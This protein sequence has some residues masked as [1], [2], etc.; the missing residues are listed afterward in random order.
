MGAK[1]VPGPLRELLAAWSAWLALDSGY[2]FMFMLKRLAYYL[3]GKINC[4][5]PVP[6]LGLKEKHT[7]RTHKTSTKFLL[8]S[9]LQLNFR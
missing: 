9:E 3:K 2:S 8:C 1:R 4:G 5:N 6:W 7:L